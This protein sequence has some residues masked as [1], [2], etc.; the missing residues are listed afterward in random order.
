[1]RKTGSTPFTA[2]FLV[3]L[4]CFLAGC[5]NL[6]TAHLEPVAVGQGCVSDHDSNT[7]A[8]GTPCSIA[9]MGLA[10]E[11]KTGIVPGGSLKTFGYPADSL[12][13]GWDDGYDAGTQPCPCWEWVSTVNRG[14][15]RFDLTK[16]L[17][18]VDKIEFAAL[19]W[20]TNKMK[21]DPAKTCIKRL[22]EA[23]GPWQ[24]GSTPVKLLADNLDA[25]APKGGYV[26]L[27]EQT[28]HWYAKPGENFGLVFEPA[29]P[30]TVAKSTS[31]CLDAVDHLRME[32]KYRQKPTQWPGQ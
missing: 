8:C 11:A 30:N 6:V 22:Y 32:V 16:L 17:G 28:Q 27:V 21:G 5:A 9:Q 1:M 26:G 31:T 25:I 10:C 23:T 3:V 4:G 18:P 29:R 19:S 20:Q 24:Y 14:Y 13:V 7:L 15:V 2:L 12:V